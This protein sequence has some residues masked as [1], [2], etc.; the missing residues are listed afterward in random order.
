MLGGNSDPSMDALKGADSTGM[1]V[2]GPSAERPTNMLTRRESMAPDGH[3]IRAPDW[4]N[5]PFEVGCAR[6]GHD[7]RG[8]TEAK[9]PACGL[10]FDWAAAV[11][12]EQLKCRHCDYHLYGLRE[13]RCPECGERF[14]WE[15]ALARYHRKRI[16][17]FE[18]QWR[19]R[20]IRSLIGTWFRAMVPGKLWKKVSIHDPPQVGPLWVMIVIILRA[21]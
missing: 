5:V 17:L 18:Y 19:E 4:E 20:P 12:I 16:A 11:P 8:R 14:T 10:E 15:E 7:L 3:G 6:C 13:T 21:A 1:G 9:C 2:G